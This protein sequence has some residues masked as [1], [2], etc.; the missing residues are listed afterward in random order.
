MSTFEKKCSFIIVL[1]V[2]ENVLN[3]A[4]QNSAKVVESDSTDRLIVLESVNQA[5]ADTVLIYKL[6]C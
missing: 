5:T 3:S 4:L 1:D 2:N 6:I